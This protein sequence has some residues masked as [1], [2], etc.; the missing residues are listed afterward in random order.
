MKSE[1]RKTDQRVFQKAHDGNSNSNNNKL[2]TTK[3]KRP[4]LKA[5]VS[6]TT[7]SYTTKFIKSLWQMHFPMRTDH[8]SSNKRERE[9]EI[10]IYVQYYQMKGKPNEKVAY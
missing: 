6:E 10:R 4:Q 1:A 3:I 7:T 5:T 2:L 8:R 9:R